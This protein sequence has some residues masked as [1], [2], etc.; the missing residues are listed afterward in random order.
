[1]KQLLLLVA[2]SMGIAHSGSAS[3]K[4]CFCKATCNFI[5]KESTD[6]YVNADV[7]CD[8]SLS[9]KKARLISELKVH[10]AS[11][12]GQIADKD[13]SKHTEVICYESSPANK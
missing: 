3:A 7:S 2:G 8:L 5:N 11:E 13:I 6:F 4:T 10:I 12:H 1:M 9:Q